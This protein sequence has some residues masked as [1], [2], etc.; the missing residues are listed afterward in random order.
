MLNPPGNSTENIP[1]TDI[2]IPVLDSDITPGEVDD[3][4]KRLKSNKAAGCDGVPPGILKWLSN[5]WILLITY[6]CNLVFNG[7]YPKEWSL[8]KVF[9]LYKS[10]GMGDP[11]NYR[12]IS[13]MSALAKI[14]EM[15]L[16]LRFSLWYQ[17]LPEQAGGQRKRG[18]E[19]QILVVCLLIDIARKTKRPL[20][21]A[22]IDYRK[23]YDKLNRSIFLC[24]LVAK[25]CGAKFVKAVSKS[26]SKTTGVIGNEQFSATEGVKQG[27]CTSCP[28]FCFYV[29][30][31][32]E[33]VKA[34]GEDGWL[35]NLNLL[36]FMDDT[37]IFATSQ[38]MLEKS[39]IY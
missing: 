29:D 38:R 9:N 13:V 16:A 15:I 19:E 23:A 32:I 26:V 17:P 4:V 21:L 3:Q 20:F 7:L 12:G 18:C 30:A 25:G 22:F 14:Y 11:G 6:M 10:G 28:M 8:L 5:T 35:G 1:E 2:F 24:M 39:F 34:C 33:A 31:T 27:S 36:L 37:V